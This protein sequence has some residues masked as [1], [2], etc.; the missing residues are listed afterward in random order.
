MAR[1]P[2]PIPS[3]NVLHETPAPIIGPTT[4]W[5]AEPPAMPN[6]CVAPMSVAAREAG[7]FVVAMYAAPIS[8]NTPPAP[9]RK[10]PTLANC[11]LP[12]ANS[13]APMPTV[14]API[15]TTLPGPSRSMATPATRLNG[16]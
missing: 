1:P 6:I 13:S 9:W 3:Q 4:A 7:K 8:A 2:M 5:P 12:D 10:R 15:G 14:A 11:V 16:E